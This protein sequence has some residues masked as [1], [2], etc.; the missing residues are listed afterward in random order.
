MAP[1]SKQGLLKQSYHINAACDDENCEREKV[2]D[3]RSVCHKT[4]VL[5][6]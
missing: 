1:C 6:T 3:K 4:S 5:Y 2:M